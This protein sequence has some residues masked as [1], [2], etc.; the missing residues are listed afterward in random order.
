[1]KKKYTKS[2]LYLC[3]ILLLFLLI[4]VGY[5]IIETNLSVNNNIS[6]VGFKSNKLYDYM[7]INSSPDNQKSTYVTNNNG[8]AF[9][10]VGSITN[11]QGIYE[12]ASTTNDKYPVF[13]YRGNINNNNVIF[14]NFCW[15]IIRTTSTGGVKIIYNGVPSSGKCNNEADATE[16]GKSVYNSSIQSISDIGYMYGHRVEVEE[17]TNM[18]LKKYKFG[19]D[20]TYS[21]GVYTLQDVYSSTS[22]YGATYLTLQQRYHYSCFSSETS[23]NPVYYISNFL[24]LKVYRVVLTDGM[25]IDDFL[26]ASTSGSSNTTSSTIKTYIDNWFANNL[27]SYTSYLEDTTFC[28]DRTISEYHMWNKDDGVSSDMRFMG[29]KR[30]FL[31]YKPE[32]VCTSLND[33]FSTTTEVGNGKLTYPVGLITADEVILCSGGTSTH[34]YTK[35]TYWTMTPAYFSD[36]GEGAHNYTNSGILEA[37]TKIN[38][39]QGVRP[40]VSLKKGTEYKSGDGTPN[41]PYIVN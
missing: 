18:S 27:L 24:P 36:T 8:I 12:M 19:N 40:V 9:N 10:A 14:A 17:I 31:T 28:N 29:Y 39:Q 38:T 1:M 35:N 32:V 16:I 15:K 4:G 7:M 11:G 21:N 23:C 5:A 34:L 2:K 22:T 20:V 41:N 6:I 3:I 26:N 37:V 25:N 33:R 13:Y 30:N